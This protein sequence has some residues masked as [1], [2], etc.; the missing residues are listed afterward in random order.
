MIA[1]STIDVTAIATPS[2]IR[3]G[4]P[5]RRLKFF[6]KKTFLVNEGHKKD[7][8][9]S[10]L[11][12]GENNVNNKLRIVQFN[13]ET[14]LSKAMRR[15]TSKLDTGEQ[16]QPLSSL[17]LLC[18]VVHI[19]LASAGGEDARALQHHLPL[20]VS[21]RFNWKDVETSQSR[22]FNLVKFRRLF[23]IYYRC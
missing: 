21:P 10:G 12:D 3:R 13:E 16:Q 19:V 4:L 1:S 5:R 2:R 6:H 18:Q 11:S 9:D 8:N 15:K 22:Y 20:A 23:S 17:L 7:Q 14:S